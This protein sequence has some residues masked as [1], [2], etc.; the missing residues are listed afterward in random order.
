MIDNIIEKYFVI[1]FLVPENILNP[2]NIL[3]LNISKYAL[4]LNFIPAKKYKYKYGNIK[5]IIGDTTP[6]IGAKNI[7]NNE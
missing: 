1:L 7:V 2:P 6:Y 3:T 4:K 5:N